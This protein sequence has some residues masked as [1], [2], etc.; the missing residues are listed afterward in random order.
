M[1]IADKFRLEADPRF[2]MVSRIEDFALLNDD[3]TVFGVAM[4]NPFPIPTD[5]AEIAAVMKV[6]ERTECFCG[7]D[8]CGRRS[9]DDAWGS[10]G[11][12]SID[13]YTMEEGVDCS[14]SEVWIPADKSKYAVPDFIQKTAALMKKIQEVISPGTSWPQVFTIRQNSSYPKKFHSHDMAVVADIF[15]EGTIFTVGGAFASPYQLPPHHIAAFHR[16]FHKAGAV[17]P[18]APRLTIVM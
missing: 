6:T 2:M 14:N 15:G 5:P 4:P 17:Q 16:I 11:E 12:L 13:R 8:G 7:R 9:D 10:Y 18:D 3:P 1:S